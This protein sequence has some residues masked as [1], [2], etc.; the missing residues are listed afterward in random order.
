MDASDSN[1][2]SLPLSVL[3]HNCAQQTLLFFQRVASDT[4]YCLEIFRR[5]IVDKNE[6]AWALLHDTYRDQIQ[7]W[8]R[9]HPAFRACHE[10]EDYFVNRSMEKFWQAIPPAQFDRFPDISHLLSYLQMCVNST[11]CGYL[12]TRARTKYEV[13]L[14]EAEEHASKELLEEDVLTQKQG[15][16][17][18]SMVIE[19][20]NNDK[21][22]QVA[23]ESFLL[24]LKPGDIFIRHAEAYENPKEIYRIKE[25]ILSRLR[26]DSDL[27]NKIGYK[28]E[29]RV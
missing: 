26:R 8:V 22:I 28:L 15:K 23:Y 14:D 11:I 20:L 10:D 12:R 17:L 1:P 7:R 9:R 29:S 16:E 3:A 2:S 18:W 5:A 19:R 4:R 13:D 25:N 21:E 6:Q 24:D 27:L